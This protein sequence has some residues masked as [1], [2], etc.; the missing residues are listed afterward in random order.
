VNRYLGGSPVGIFLILRFFVATFV[1]LLHVSPPIYCI[2]YRCRPHDSTAQSQTGHCRNIGQ[3]TIH[4]T[5][6][7]LRLA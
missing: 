3:P 5:Q 6:T 2:G 7:N 1:Q 4:S